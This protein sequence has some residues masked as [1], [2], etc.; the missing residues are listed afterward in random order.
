MNDYTKMKDTELNE[1]VS[2]A[3]GWL[4][5][6]ANKCWRD[7]YDQ[8]NS[9]KEWSTDLNYAILLIKEIQVSG[10]DFVRFVLTANNWSVLIANRTFNEWSTKSESLPRAICL[11]YLQWKDIK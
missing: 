9:I 3:L 1:W 2:L 8:M 7:E 10:V 6:H 5:D 11:A 4:Y